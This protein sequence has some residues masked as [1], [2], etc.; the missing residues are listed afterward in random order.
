MRVIVLGPARLPN[1]IEEAERLRPLIET[2]A[3]VVLADFTDLFEG[4]VRQVLVHR[5]P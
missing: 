5:D 1:V 3:R 4:E 2:H